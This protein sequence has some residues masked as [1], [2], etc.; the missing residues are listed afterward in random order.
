MDIYG[1]NIGKKEL[2]SKIGDI[3]H[4]GGLRSF[5]FND[6]PSKDIRAYNIRNAA[7]LSFNILIDRGMDISELYY[8]EVPFSLTTPIRVSSPYFFNDRDDGFLRSFFGGFLTTCGITYMGEPCV[9]NR[10]ELGLHGRISNIPAEKTCASGEWEKDNYKISISGRIRETKLYGSYL[11]LNR[12]YTIFMDKPVI[13]LIDIIE[14]IGF[15]TSPVMILYHFN[16][17]YPLLDENTELF[18]GKSEVIPTDYGDS[19]KDFKQYNKFSGPIKDYEFQVFFHNI[20][21]DK[22]NYSNVA[23]INESF[24]NNQGIGISLKYNKDSLPYLIQWKYLAEGEYV[25]G[26]E[27]SNSLVRGRKIEREEGNLKTLEPGEKMIFDLE[28]RILESNKEI[29]RYRTESY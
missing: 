11:E 24:N 21:P 16:F 7:G 14:N 17:S 9:D 20:E 13:H 15:R 3:E 29:D 8:K 12:N 27:P 23:L 4:L 25:C 2:I 26:L 19:K 22:D 1:K 10:E 5:T 6:G 28:I 18:S